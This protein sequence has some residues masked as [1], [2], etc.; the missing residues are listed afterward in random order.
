MER[1]PEWRS[2]RL[3]LVEPDNKWQ[4]LEA[5]DWRVVWNRSSL[6][7]RAVNENNGEPFQELSLATGLLAWLAWEAGLMLR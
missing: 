6:G 1:R 7:P 3:R 5:G 4:L 2:K